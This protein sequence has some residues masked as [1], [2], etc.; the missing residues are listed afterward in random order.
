MSTITRKTKD[1][2]VTLDGQEFDTLLEAQRC[3]GINTLQ[4]ELE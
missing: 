4:G 3:L 1:V 2:S